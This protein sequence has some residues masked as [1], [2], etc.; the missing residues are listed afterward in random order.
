MLLFYNKLL[1]KKARKM[2][3]MELFFY[4]ITSFYSYEEKILKKILYKVCH[5][6]IQFFRIPL[7]CLAVLIDNKSSKFFDVRF[8][9]FV[10]WEFCN[11]VILKFLM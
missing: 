4:Y 9:N 11:I 10:I 2:A 8:C 3:E 7:V 5:H 6:S 1:G